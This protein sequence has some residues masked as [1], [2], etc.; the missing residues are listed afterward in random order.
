MT[1]IV[2]DGTTLAADRLATSQGHKAIVDKLFRLN[3]GGLGAYMGCPTHGNML[4]DWYNKGADPEKWPKPPIGPDDNAHLVVVKTDGFVYM[5]EGP[6]PFKL[7]DRQWAGGVG[8]AYAVGAMAMG[9][10]A[11]VAASVA[12]THHAGCGQG[13]MSMRLFPEPD[14]MPAPVKPNRPRK[15]TAGKRGTRGPKAGS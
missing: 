7:Y 14:P 15:S 3:D 2:W 9:A 11:M 4:L 10:N 12:C 5:F 6:V 13:I 1:V 8:R